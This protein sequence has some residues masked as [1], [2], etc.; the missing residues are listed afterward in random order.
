M[1]VGNSFL[2]VCNV[3]VLILFPDLLARLGHERRIS[4]FQFYFNAGEGFISDAASRISGAVA[5]C[6]FELK[7]NH[8]R[9]TAVN[10]AARPVEKK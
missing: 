3:F 6:T 9:L 4:L 8:G 5:N 10:L 7:I 1:R 2:F